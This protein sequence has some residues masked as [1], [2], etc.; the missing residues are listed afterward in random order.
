VYNLYHSSGNDVFDGHAYEKGS[1][2]LHMLRFVL[3]ETAFWR[4]IQHYIQS[5]RGREV[6]TADLERAIEESSGRSMGRFFEQWVY[7]AGHP[8][9]EV[10]FNWD[11]DHKLASLTVKQTQEID[12]HHPC[13][14]T[15]VDIAFTLPIADD[16]PEGETTTSTFRV[17]IEEA[18]QRF[19]FPLPR[20]PLAVRFD[21]GGWILK[22][23]TFERSAEMLRYQLVHDPDVLGRIEAAEELGK[24]GD[25]KSAEALAQ[26][27]LTDAFWGVRAEVAATLGK[28]RTEAA[29]TALLTALEQERDPKARR[30]IVAALGSF[31]VPEQPELAERAASA[32]AAL[33]KQGDPSY[34]VEGA[35]ATALGKTRTS[36][37]FEQLVA[38]LDR[39]SWNEIIRA[40]V[41]QGLAALG[42]PA[43]AGV[44]AGWLDRSKPIQARA[45]AAGALGTLAKD[46]RLD[47]GE[48]RQQAVN[49]LLGGLDDPWTPVRASAARSLAALRETSALGALDQIAASD[50]DGRLVRTVRLAA[51]AIREG[52]AAGDEVRQLRSDFDAMKEE[53]RKLRERLEALEARLEKS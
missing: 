14:V 2:V 43:A 9:F 39:P 16:A 17:Q 21:P 31:R 22:T 46:H 32:L 42:D 4:A 7:R 49:A 45:A 8:E 25:P 12:E 40:G 34:F 20:K 18:Q 1:L 53:N 5:N 41:F 51:K 33:L 30:G 37:A 35:A 28:L 29:L 15:P 36:G 27:L 52:K 10:A 24:L 44:L 19:V 26:A 23:L 13:F 6:I 47:H 50:L 3:G 38:A 11:S 48:P